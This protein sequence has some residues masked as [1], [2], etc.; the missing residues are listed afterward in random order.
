M[1]SI[2]DGLSYFQ[3]FLPK[4][5]DGD[6]SIEGN[7]DAK[8]P[9]QNRPGETGVERYD[10][11]RFQ[12]N[13][14][15][16]QDITLTTQEGDVVTISALT[17]IQADYMAFDYTGQ[18]KGESRSMNFQG[19]KA[20]ATDAF[21]MTVQGDLNAEEQEDIEK[22]LGKLGGIMDD[23]V[24]GDLESVMKEAVGVL[25]DTDTISQLNATLQFHQQV[26]ME[27]KTLI[28]GPRLDHPGNGRPPMGP[29]P[30]HAGLNG[31]LES[32]NNIIAKITDQLTEI[33]ESSDVENGKLKEPVDKLFARFMEK[34]NTGEPVD[35]LKSGLVEQIQSNLLEKM[36]ETAQPIQD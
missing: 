14:E 31:L 12:A 30:G 36:G 26:S 32:A 21:K 19:L 24:S 25:D 2:D 35:Q 5:E 8:H 29:P 3:K 15:E 17:Q 27:Q 11:F 1:V 6:Q 10:Q 33:I 18:V 20:E 16:S 22:V 23:L 13:R 9:A 4:Q 34:L 28:R 7:K